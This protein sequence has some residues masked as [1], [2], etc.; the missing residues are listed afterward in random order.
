LEA[1]NYITPLGLKRLEDEYSFLKKTER[2]KITALVSWAASLGDRSENADYIYGKKR[3]REI[4]R[5]MRFL[6]KRIAAAQVVDPEV[7]NMNSIKFGATVSLLDEEERELIYRI[8]GVDEFDTKA[9]RISW[10]SPIATS[11]LGKS[12]GDVVTVRT[13]S[14][15]REFEITQ[16]DYKKIEIE[17]FKGV[18]EDQC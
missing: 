8:V 11:L 5:R 14:G 15:D 12:V 1:P 9:M 13:P 4:D 2:P 10:R 7:Q 6:S 16:I 18:S 17:E 3:L